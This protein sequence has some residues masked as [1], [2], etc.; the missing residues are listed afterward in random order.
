MGGRQ[1]P[2]PYELAPAPGVVPDNAGAMYQRGED[3][4]IR[5]V[6]A[7]QAAAQ[8]AQGTGSNI[9]QTQLIQEGQGNLI[10]L[11]PGVLPPGGAAG[12]ALAPGMAPGMAGGFPGAAGGYSPGA[13]PMNGYPVGGR[14]ADDRTVVNARINLPSTGAYSV[15]YPTNPNYFDP[16]DGRIYAAQG[17]GQ[18]IAQP[19]APNVEMIYNYSHGFPGSRLTPV[20]RMPGQP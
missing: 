1:I 3:G 6:S 8:A 16:R 19:L 11:E 15:A 4:A 13:Y 14:P 17:Y 5:L 9:Q 10:P 7:E 18:P 2:V 20:S 12:P